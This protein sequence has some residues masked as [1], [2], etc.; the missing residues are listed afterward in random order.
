MCTRQLE[1]E[2]NHSHK[3]IEKLHRELDKSQVAQSQ[4]L[5]LEKIVANLKK[6]KKEMFS[7]VEQ[8]EQE[9]SLI[10]DQRDRLKDKLKGA[11][12][13]N[14]DFAVLSEKYSQL[15]QRYLASQRRRH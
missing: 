4:I 15:E 10:A 3:E 9:T 12:S 5:Q 6:E 11:N 13:Q 8:L 2:L 1:Q 14:Q 7:I